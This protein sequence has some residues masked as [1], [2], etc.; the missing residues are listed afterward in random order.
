MVSPLVYSTPVAMKAREETPKFWS[1]KSDRDKF[2]P[3]K[4]AVGN[5]SAFFANSA[6]RLQS[7]AHYHRFTQFSGKHRC[8][9]QALNL[10]SRIVALESRF[11]SRP[12]DVEE[13]RR[14]DD[15]IRCVTIPPLLL[16]LISP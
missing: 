3:L 2:G 1:A 14:R 16:V 11:D 15:L 4:F 5:I 9:E 6:V 13:Q 10:L 12:S 8:G 7:P